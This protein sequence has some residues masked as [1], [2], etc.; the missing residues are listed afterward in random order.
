[1][2][3][4]TRTSSNINSLCDYVV[5]RVAAWRRRLQ[6]SV[7][8][9]RDRGACIRCEMP[10]CSNAFHPMCAKT[11]GVYMHLEPAATTE[12]SCI[13]GQGPR[14]LPV[15]RSVYCDLHRPVISPARPDMKQCQLNGCLKTSAV[16]RKLDLNGGGDAS[17]AAVV[18]TSLH[19]P[20]DKYVLML[21]LNL[22]INTC[23]CKQ[24]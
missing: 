12:P 15:R 23:K 2:T 1:M 17:S 5:F 18:T 13:P 16:V 6:C 8:K 4:I 19:I 14:C 11:S 24:L 7:C 22:T 21:W 3:A 9:L 20:T 10:S